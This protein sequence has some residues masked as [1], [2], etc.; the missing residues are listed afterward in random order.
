M[1]SQ[2]SALFADLTAPQLEGIV[3]TFEEAVFAD[4]ERILRQGLSG[5]GFHVIL[6][7][8]AAVVVDGTE[9]ARLGRGDFFGEVSILL[10]ESPIAD[11]V[12]IAAAALPRPRRPGA[13]RRS[14]SPTRGSCTG[15]SRPRPA[16]CAP[17]TDGGA[18]PAR[19]RRATTRSSSSAAGPARSR[20]RTRCAGSGVDHAV[21][22]ADPSP[23]G[24]F[25]RWPFFQRLLSWTKPHAPVRARQSRAYERYDWNS[26]LG[27]EPEATARSSRTLM[28]GT[29]LL[30]VAPGDGG[31]PRRVRRAR[32][33]RRPLRL[34]LDRR[35][36]GVETADGDRASSVETTD[37]AVSLPGARRR[38]R[39][40][41]AVHAAR[42]RDGAHATT[43]PTSARPRPTPVGAS[44][45]S[46]SRTPGSSSRPGCC[47]G[48]ASSSWCR[49]R[50]RSC[51]STPGRSSA[52][53]PATSSRTRTTSWAAASRSSTPRSTG[54]SRRARRAR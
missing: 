21:I 37:G 48:P 46:A 5:S 29:S 7:G 52:S 53:G 9:R 12:A 34:P 33:D 22:S 36:A 50:T 24:M 10:G 4:G 43:T 27:D 14:S 45:S 6:D 42:A 31:Q 1:R 51:R 40:R 13:S 35:R 18:D 38:G 44:A 23:G 39:R 20:C 30:P 17:R 49:R 47:R 19:S 54:S 16:G 15:C 8:E 3:H 41:R 28:D 25:R 26:L 11:V 2:G 32:R